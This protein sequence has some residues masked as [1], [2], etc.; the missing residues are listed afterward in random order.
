[1]PDEERVGAR[2]RTARGAAAG[3]L[4]AAPAALSHALTAGSA[5]APASLAV[6]VAVS[7]V[8]CVLLT[9]RRMGPV[10]LFAAV[11]ASQGGYHLLYGQHG[12]GPTD[13]P[14]HDHDAG[15]LAAHLVAAVLSALAVRH[16]ERAWWALVDA[17]R[18]DVRLLRLVRAPLVRAERPL[19]RGRRFFL[20]ALRDRGPAPGTITR[21]GPPGRTA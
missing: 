21:R 18:A 11:A 16:G 5:P 2:A 1:M 10:R 19:R 13:R 12:P 14:G 3:L 7:T 9:G 15:M 20:R 4:C 17:L 8:V 6:A